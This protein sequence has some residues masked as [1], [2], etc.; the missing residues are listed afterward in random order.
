MESISVRFHLL[1]PDL[2]N[3]VIVVLLLSE[4]NHSLMRRL[5]LQRTWRPALAR[6]RIKS[7]KPRPPALALRMRSSG[8]PQSQGTLPTAQVPGWAGKPDDADKP[9]FEELALLAPTI[10]PD[11]PRSVIRFGDSAAKIL[12][13]SALVIERKLEMLNIFLVHKP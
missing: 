4:L 2:L 8:T 10:I 9:M 7:S 11:D 3:W 12:D 6:N 1:N 5:L 13:N